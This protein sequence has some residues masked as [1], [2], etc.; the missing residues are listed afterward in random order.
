M[1]FDELNDSGFDCALMMLRQAAEQVRLLLGI[2]VM[3]DD[4][5]S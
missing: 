4:G 1:S 3:P 5:L 2:V